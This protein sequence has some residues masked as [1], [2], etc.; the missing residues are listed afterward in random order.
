MKRL[1]VLVL[2]G[3]LTVSAGAF[4]ANM[5][6]PAKLQVAL[7]YKIFSYDRRLKAS[8]KEELLLGV[9]FVPGNNISE[10][11]K[12]EILDEFGKLSDN[13]I[14]NKR[15]T[16]QELSSLESIKGLDIVYVT[17]GNE[18]LIDDIVATCNEH[19]VLGIAGGEEYA[20]KGLAVSLGIESGKPVIIINQNGAKACGANFSSQLLSLA[21]II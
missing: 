21:R 14:A 19:K 2:L 3:I 20:Q 13:T 12:D 18:R 11:G 5:A 1:S 17:R 4:A 8:P 10:A 9:F 15:I 16:V 7:F 6:L